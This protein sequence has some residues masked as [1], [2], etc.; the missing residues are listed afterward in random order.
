VGEDA[1]TACYEQIRGTHAGVPDSYHHNVQ[2]V[3]VIEVLEYQGKGLNLTWEV[4]DGVAHHTGPDEPETL[5]GRIVRLADRIAYVNHDIDDAVRGDVISDADLPQHAVEVLGASHGARIRTMVQDTIAASDD[6]D[7]IRMSPAVWD[8][9]M[10]L[11]TYLFDKVYLSPRAKEEE[12]K[13][14]GVVQALFMHYLEHPEAMPDEYRVG[15]AGDLVQ[16]V[17]DYV[18]GMTDRFAIGAYQEI[19][20]PSS[21]RM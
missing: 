3:R 6:L 8:A 10:E 19:F 5:E 12:P 20:V 16:R 13:S 2:S 4:R 21:W 1:L 14:F 15:G 9:M 17:T 7:T 11:R 18:A